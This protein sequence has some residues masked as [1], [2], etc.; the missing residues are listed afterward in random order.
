MSSMFRRNAIGV[1]VLAS[2]SV[3]AFAQPALPAT[4]T[5]TPADDAAPAPPADAGAAAEGTLSTVEV[6]E[7]RATSARMAL[8]PQVGTTVYHIDSTFID[9]LAKGEATSFDE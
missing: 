4:S 8:S 2:L 7:Q 6:R 5:P 1:A 3:A 9:S